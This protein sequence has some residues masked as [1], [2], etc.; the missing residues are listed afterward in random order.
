MADAGWTYR[1]E[2]YLLAAAIAATA[3]ALPALQ[4]AV[5]REPALALVLVVPVAMLAGRCAMATVNLPKYSRAIYTQQYQMARFVHRYYEGEAIAANDIGA[6]NFFS[7]VR[8]VDLV[9]LSNRDIFFAKR[10]DSYTTEVIDRESQAVHASIAIVYDAWFSNKPSRFGGPPLPGQWKRIARW[11]VSDKEEL[12]SDIV[13][14]YAIK[15][16]EAEQLRQELQEFDGSLP[17]GVT[18]IQN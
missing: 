14:F 11:K 8:C 6:I 3:F 5:R 18:V 1:Y 9:G 10:S 7:D 16:K 17:P 4:K 2:D 13:S 12:G 15:P